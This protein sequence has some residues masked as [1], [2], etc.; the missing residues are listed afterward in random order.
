MTSVRIHRTWRNDDNVAREIA[1]LRRGWPWN[2]GY[3]RFW[4]SLPFRRPSSGFVLWTM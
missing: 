1:A 3:W 4:K 2:L